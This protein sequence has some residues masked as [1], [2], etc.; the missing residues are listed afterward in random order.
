MAA[1]NHSLPQNRNR[2]SIQARLT[3]KT[4]AMAV[5]TV[6]TWKESWIGNQSIEKWRLAF[7]R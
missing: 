5:A 2:A 3:P 6:E 1:S 7:Q 4:K